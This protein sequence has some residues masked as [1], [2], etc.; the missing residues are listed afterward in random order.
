M[1]TRIY[2]NKI[3]SATYNTGHA[4]F[5]PKWP[6]TRITCIMLPV[7][8]V[9]FYHVLLESNI[10]DNR[11]TWPSKIVVPPCPPE[12]PTAPLHRGIPPSL[13]LPGRSR[14]PWRQ[15]ASPT[16]LSSPILQC[17]GA[18]HRLARETC[19]VECHSDRG[20][21]ARESDGAALIIFGPHM[22]F[23]GFF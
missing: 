1:K 18:L 6:C 21:Y 10:T 20:L 2:T 11:Q 13:S 14:E 15:E 12:W 22:R 17:Q 7:V 9:I 8:L 3:K 16:P 23:S 4:P 19:S 5:L